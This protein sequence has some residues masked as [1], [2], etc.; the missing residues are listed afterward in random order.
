VNGDPHGKP[1]AFDL[2]NEQMDTFFRTGEI[3]DL[4][5]GDGCHPN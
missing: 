5:G 4:C 3:V 1:R 2:H